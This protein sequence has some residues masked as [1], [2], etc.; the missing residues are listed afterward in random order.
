MFGI[1][2]FH[3]SI[4]RNSKGSNTNNAFSHS[5]NVDA[6][7]SPISKRDASSLPEEL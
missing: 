6:I 5:E 2:V 7:K 4:F 1:S 3:T